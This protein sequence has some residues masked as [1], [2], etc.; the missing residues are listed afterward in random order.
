MGVKG[1]G[2]QAGSDLR[3]PASHWSPGYRVTDARSIRHALT[4]P[5]S[6][7]GT[8]AEERSQYLP[9]GSGVNGTA[10]GPLG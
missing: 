4:P 8:V 3:G 5:K 7:G 1:F 2:R 9:V 6:H 10:R